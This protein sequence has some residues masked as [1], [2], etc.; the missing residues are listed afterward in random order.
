[1]I[2]KGSVKCIGNIDERNRVRVGVSIITSVSD[3]K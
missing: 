3:H 2:D 1:M